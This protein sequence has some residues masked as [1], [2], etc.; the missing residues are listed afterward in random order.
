MISPGD[1]EQGLAQQGL[2][3]ARSSSKPQSYVRTVTRGR[4]R[5][6]GMQEGAF[7]VQRMGRGQRE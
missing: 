1:R 3:G 4:S 5:S 7:S 6:C 2:G